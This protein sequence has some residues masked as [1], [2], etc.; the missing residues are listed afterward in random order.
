MNNSM[1]P[2][3]LLMHAEEYVTVN[4]IGTPKMSV[5]CTSILLYTVS[6]NTI[7]FAPP[8][9]KTALAPLTDQLIKIRR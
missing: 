5:Y 1:V 4:P 8:L 3:M 2:G 9:N 7:L 6:Y